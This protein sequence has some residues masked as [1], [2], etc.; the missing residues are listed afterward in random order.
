MGCI[1]DHSSDSDRLK[2][3]L[4]PRLSKVEMLKLPRPTVEQGIQ[5]PSQ[6]ACWNG[7]IMWRQKN[8]QVV[9]MWGLQNRPSSKASGT[10]WWE[11][12]QHHGK[13][14]GAALVCSHGAGPLISLM[15]MCQQVIEVGWW[16]FTVTNQEAKL[17]CNFKVEG[18]A[19]KDWPAGCV[20]VAHRQ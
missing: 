19:E 11:G 3:G 5:R 2:R 1:I 14:S 17:L 16:N 6:V 15:T 10:C 8:H 12:Y 4:R 18:A 9:L 13:S 7:Y 20:E